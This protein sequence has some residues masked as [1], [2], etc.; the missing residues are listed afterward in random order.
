MLVDPELAHDPDEIYR[1]IAREL[2]AVLSEN[3]CSVREA[4]RSLKYAIEV[5]RATTH[6]QAVVDI[7]SI[8]DDIGLAFIY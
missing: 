6:V 2:I 8:P 3:Q 4:E 1:N 5:V 7:G